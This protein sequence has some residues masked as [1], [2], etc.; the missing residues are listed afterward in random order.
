MRM[1]IEQPS[2]STNNLP[3]RNNSG[4]YRVQIGAKRDKEVS[5]GFL[6]MVMDVVRE[7]ARIEMLDAQRRKYAKSQT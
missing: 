5:C 6:E 4:Y 2:A 1:K 7:R 3:D